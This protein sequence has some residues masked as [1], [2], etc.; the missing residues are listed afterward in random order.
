LTAQDKIKRVHWNYQ[1]F[2]KIPTF[3]KRAK[4]GDKRKKPAIW[5]VWMGEKRLFAGVLTRFKRF[6]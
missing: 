6:L 1:F 5:Q 3:E 2:A 4:V